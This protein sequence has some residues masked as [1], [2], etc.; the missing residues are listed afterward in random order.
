MKTT[1]FSFVIMLLTLSSYAQSLHNLFATVTIT[2]T[3]AS[4]TARPEVIATSNRVFVLYLAITGTTNTFD[5]KIYNSNMDTLINSQV[6]VSPT[7]SYGKPTDIRVASDGQYLYAFYETLKTISFGNDSTSLWAAKY[8]LNDNFT[9]VAGTPVPITR[10]K[11]ATQLSIG[12]EKVDDPA[13]LM[14]PN[15]VYAIT[16]LHDSIKTT[17]STIYRVREFDNNN[18]TQLSQFD[19]DLSDVADGRGRVTSLF[20]RQNNI[21]IA[22]TTTV[23]NVGL[24][25]N[26][27]DGA[28]SDIILIKMQPD[29][30]YNPT[31]D[32][33][34]L[35]AEINDHENYVSGLDMDN[36][37]L[38]V[39]YKQAT[40]SPP[41]GQQLAWIKIYD[42]NFNFVDTIMVKSTVWGPSGEEIRPSLDVY[43]SRIYSGQ[44]MAPISGSGY[45]KVFVYDFLLTSVN[46]NS[47]NFNLSPA[48]FPNPFS[49]QT[50]LLIDI[51][52]NN[53]TLTVYNSFGQTVKEIK[54][55]SGQTVTLSRDNLL[56]GLY[57]IRLTEDSKVIATDKLVITD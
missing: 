9:L 34:T 22:L 40:G 33:F 50:T 27:D 26:S 44:S 13:P 41:T 29:W 30:T 42:N 56:S 45:A 4:K 37:Y 1:I 7:S 51:P 49:T 36:N 14:G 57:F 2:D 16:R 11:P 25:E 46:D 20:Y 28:L 38:Y 23:S 52:L 6:L 21:Y 54:N 47:E 18:F 12:G 24:Y 17:G 35:T 10:S 55:I 15:S 31:T 43:G 3:A 39:T 19:L 5:L 53:A 8:L 32:V 48:I